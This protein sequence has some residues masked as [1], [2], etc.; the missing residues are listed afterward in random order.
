MDLTVYLVA[1]SD[2]QWFCNTVTLLQGHMRVQ[3]ANVVQHQESNCFKGSKPNYL[4]DGKTLPSDLCCLHPWSEQL[5]GRLLQLSV[6]MGIGLSPQHLQSDISNMVDFGHVYPSFQSKFLL[7]MAR[8]TDP[9]ALAYSYNSLDSVQA[10]L[11]ISF[12]SAFTAPQK[13]ILLHQ[14]GPEE[15][16]VCTYSNFWETPPGPLTNQTCCLKVP[17][18]SGALA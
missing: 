12:E 1:K 15:P 18:P 8:T 13:S 16:Q 10:N 7:F 4:M 17:L 6:P 2:K 3:W 14:V 9:L 5:E 11:C